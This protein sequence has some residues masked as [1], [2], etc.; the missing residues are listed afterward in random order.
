[1]H[2]LAPKAARRDRGLWRTNG[3]VGN[4]LDQEADRRNRPM[5]C[6][7]IETVG[8]ERW[9]EPRPRTTQGYARRR[10]MERAMGIEPTAG[11]LEAYKA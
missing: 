11:L 4:D 6:S 8:T 1:V 2:F 7:R 10:K 5:N 9:T 3:A